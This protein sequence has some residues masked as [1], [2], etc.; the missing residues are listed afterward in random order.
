MNAPTDLEIA[1]RVTMDSIG[2]VAARLGIDEA[3]VDPYGKYKAKIALSVIDEAKAAEGKLILVTAM[4]PTPAGEGKTT[5][6]V[7]LCDG[8]NRIG[9]R[10]VAVLREPSLGPCFGMKGGATGG[11]RSQVVPME[12]I[13]LHFMGDFK[14]VETANNL[15]ASLI[16]NELRLSS[17]GAMDIDPRSVTWKRVMD[18]NAR[19]LRN[20]ITGLG[21]KAGGVPRETGFN[22]TAASEIMAIL[23]L[24]RDL[25]DLK[26]KL[27]N[28]FVGR[29]YDGRA[30]YARDIKANGPLAVILKEAIKP[31]LV[32]TLEKNAAVIHGGPFANIAQGTNSILATRMGLTL[33]DYAVTEAG[34]GADLGAEKFF[35]I[36]CLYGGFKPR[37]VV[38][39]AT[40]RALKH[41]GGA[42]LADLE[43]TNVAGVRAGFVNLAKHIDNVAGFGVPS[44]V[45]INRFTADT[46]EEIKA[47]RELCADKGV[48][49]EV[50]D[51]WT[52]GGEGA[53]TLAELVAETADGFEGEFKPTYDWDSGVEEKIDAVARKIYGA[54]SVILTPKASAALRKV[55]QLGLDRLPICIAKTQYSFSDN[56]KRIGRPEG[57]ELAVSDIEIAAGAGFLIPVTGNIV[58]MPGL[59]K[60]PAARHMDIDADGN[61][62][63]LI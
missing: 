12:D 42:A 28:I 61:I 37:A 8:L 11:G 39:V 34:F 18:M 23:C 16:D 56:P 27:G 32:Q 15:L 9:K 52:H 49:A 7:G 54:G 4:T 62:T 43:R 2:D 50:N 19:A 36:K 51:S 17:N 41:H 31:N 30:V 26:E 47:V 14:A 3:D 45:A 44:V 35:N 29:S 6:S 40:V 10:A 1:Q 60:S 25:M 24:S 63:G 38:I 53:A 48:R 55:K 58:R 59:P 21:G 33:G 5:T 13:N 22:I 46:D 20:I 57:F